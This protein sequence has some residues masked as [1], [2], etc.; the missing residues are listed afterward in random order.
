MVCWN[1]CCHKT[2]PQT[3]TGLRP[4]VWD[5]CSNAYGK[6]CHVWCCLDLGGVQQSGPRYA[7]PRPHYLRHAAGKDQPKGHDQVK[8]QHYSKTIS[9]GFFQCNYEVLF[10][11]FCSEPS[12]DTEFQHFL[13][14]KEIVLTGT[15][16]PKVKGLTS[17][18]C[19]AMVR[20]SRLPAFKDLVAK[21][22]ADEVCVWRFSKN[23]FSWCINS[24]CNLFFFLFFL[25]ILHVDW[26]Q[27]SRAGSSLPV[28]WGEAVKWVWE[29]AL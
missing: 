28:V 16:L 29:P 15:V 4:R 26:E 10:S 9:W 11:I 23:T 5:N 25:A 21:V 13:R 2:V 22:E 14:G 6:H 3:S 24:N 7:A 19:E 1:N 8:H 20:L 17:D 27:H 18:Q 12:Y